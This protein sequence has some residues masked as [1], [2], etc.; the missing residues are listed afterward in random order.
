M[1]K[2][3]VG[4]STHGTAAGRT[5]SKNQTKKASAHMEVPMDQFI[6]ALQ[7]SMPQTSANMVG[8]MAPEALD[9]L[10][11]RNY[12]YLPPDYLKK[13]KIA[14]KKTPHSVHVDDLNGFKTEA[15][16]IA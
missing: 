4:H 15:A 6:R 9:L 10:N 16:A 2:N 11:P 14:G 13:I 7:Q 3:S 12:K 5:R 8:P 1:G